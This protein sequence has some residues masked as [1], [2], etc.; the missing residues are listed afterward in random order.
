ML[1]W[2]RVWPGTTTATTTDVSVIDWLCVIVVLVWLGGVGLMAHAV[3]PMILEDEDTPDLVR[4]GMREM[5]E[6]LA[7]PLAIAITGWPLAMPVLIVLSKRK[8]E[9]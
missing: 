4:L 5:P 7:L 9:K 2:L 1:G 3:V 8:K 6:L